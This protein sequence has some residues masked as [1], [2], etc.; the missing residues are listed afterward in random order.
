MKQVTSAPALSG[1]QK[2]FTFRAV[3]YGLLIGLVLMC[4]MAYLDIVMGMDTNVATI[5][6]MIG[7]LVVPTIGGPTDGKL[8]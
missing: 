8:T 5:A 7:I 4:V 2:D 1:E 3:F 6:S